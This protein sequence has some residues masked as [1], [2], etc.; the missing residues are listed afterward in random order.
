MGELGEKARSRTIKL[1]ELKG[2]SFTI[3]NYGSIGG[4]WGQPIINHPDVA[5]LGTGR[6]HEKAMVV[7]GKVVVRKV[8][9]L[10]L[11]F[12]HRVIDGAEATR[13]LND[14]KA[15]LEDP[16]LFLVDVA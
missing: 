10:S 7:D 16:G 9:P 13:F 15:D 8:L 1:E 14:L 4:L 11:T 3:T 12:D 2:N 5:I 6:I